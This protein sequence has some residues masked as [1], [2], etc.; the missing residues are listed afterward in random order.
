[1]LI[2]ARKN[3]N[4]LCFF[5]SDAETRN[6]KDRSRTV[7][8]GLDRGSVWV[9]TESSQEH[10]NRF[11]CVPFIERIQ[12]NMGLELPG[13]IDPHLKW[14]TTAKG[15]QRG[16]R[17]ARTSY[18]WGNQKN[19]MVNNFRSE[20]MMHKGLKR[21]G[22]IS[23]SAS[24]KV[25]VSI[26]GRR[27]S[28]SLNNVPIK[29]RKILLVSSPSSTLQS[30]YSDDSDHLLESQ[31]AFYLETLAYDKNHNKRNVAD[32]LTILDDINEEAGDVVD[33]S[34]MSI[35]A[36]AACSS[37]IVSDTL[38]IGGIVSKGYSF[39]AELL[40]ATQGAQSHSSYEDKEW[41]SESIQ[42]LQENCNVPV[43]ECSAFKPA[44]E[45]NLQGSESK[46]SFTVSLQNDS[47]KIR[48]SVSDS[49]L[50]WDLNTVM[51]AWNS[52]SDAA[53]VSEPLPTDPVCENLSHNEKLADFETFQDR[54]GNAE[55]TCSTGLGES[56]ENVADLPKDDCASLKSE[57]WEKPDSCNN[58]SITDH[59][60][61]KR[62]CS[63]PYSDCLLEENLVTASVSLVNSSE[64][65]E[66]VYNQRN[67]ICSTEVVSSIAR[68]IL[69]SLRDATL[70]IEAIDK[71]TADADSGL[72]SETETSLC[73]LPCSGNISSD[74]HNDSHN[75]YLNLVQSIRKPISNE[76][77]NL[78]ASNTE[79]G[80]DDH[81]VANAEVEQLTYI[82]IS[83][84]EEHRVLNTDLE[85][86]DQSSVL[87]EKDC[88]VLF[89][90]NAISNMVETCRS[91]EI[92]HSDDIDVTNGLHAK[93]SSRAVDGSPCLL[94]GH[95]QINLGSFN[96]DVLCSI[97]TCV[98]KHEQSTTELKVDNDKCVGSVVPISVSADMTVKESLVVNAMNTQEAGKSYMDSCVNYS[99]EVALN[100]HVHNYDS[101]ASHLDACQANGMEK[102][103]LLVDEDSQFEDGEFRESVLQSWGED[104]AEERE[105]AHLDYGSDNRENAIVEA[106]SCFPDSLPSIENM[107]GKSRDVSVAIHDGAANI[108]NSLFVVSQPSLMCLSK[109]TSLNS[110]DGKKT[111]TDIGRKD[112][113]DHL[114]VKMIGQ[115]GFQ[116]GENNRSPPASVGM[117]YSGWDR[118][119]V[120]CVH[121][122]DGMLDTGIG[123][124]K[125]DG[126]AG[127][128]DESS[129]NELVGRSGLSFSRGFSSRVERLMSSD[130]SH[131]Q[132]NSSARITRRDSSSRITRSDDH[133]GLNT[134]IE[135]NTG[136]PKSVG[137]GRPSQHPQGMVR[138]VHCFDCS[139]HHCPKHPGSPGYCDA[140]SARPGSRNAAAAAAAKVESNGFVVA[141]DG[142]IAKAG[143][144]GNA[145]RV[146]RQ[147]T[148][149]SSQS[150]WGSQAET[151]LACGVQRRFGNLRDMSPVQHFSVSRSQA[152]KYGHE[153]ARDRYHRPVPDDR[154]NLSRPV[155]HSS[156]RDRGFS[157]QRG[158]LCLSRSRTRSPSRSR[159]PSPHLWTS[160]RR[161]EIGMNNVLGYSRGSRSLRA[162][163]ER[164]R[165]PHLRSSVEDPT[166]RTFASPL[167]YSRWIDERRDSSNHLRE[168]DYRQRSRRSPS[169]KAFTNSKLDSVHSHGRSEPNG[170]H[171][172]LHSDKNPEI[173]GLSR[174]YK[175][176]GSDDRRGCGNRK[177]RTMV[178]GCCTKEERRK[179]KM[180]WLEDPAAAWY[181]L[182]IPNCE[183]T[184]L[185][186]ESVKTVSKSADLKVDDNN[187]VGL[188]A[189]ISI[190]A[191]S[192]MA[193]TILI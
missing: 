7:H 143:G 24:E 43:E 135:R 48:S 133:G 30:T 21:A 160:P 152:G 182:V 94:N 46:K 127:A 40:E 105:S 84:I 81:S 167:H 158:S 192:A 53:V 96:P 58:N 109:S 189:P 106:V 12:S 117:K 20:G 166:L 161:R 186:Q 70:V 130:E 116:D 122:R 100:D 99:G 75:P 27:F 179:D 1:M 163:M 83:Q 16:A 148:N 9:S 149:A 170:H 79:S 57:V 56:L 67:S 88:D 171:C 145:G 68:D 132:D 103:N 66:V 128:L 157:P 74:F 125:Q 131:R 119:P 146:V 29:K 22:D 120:A 18:A 172:H 8:K 73:L 44:D 154:M 72:M 147:S 150:R 124:V 86:G 142:T 107:T 50:H 17:R 136:A 39:E 71:A 80:S 184:F 2:F 3:K 91:G 65:T 51:D 156:R 89:D 59:D 97:I 193:K 23:V 155:H 77:P 176:A 32:N 64:E 183:S 76:K 115:G 181:D 188:V 52:N 61:I 69:G 180:G 93:G 25:G 82:S 47:D 178:G 55:G 13:P 114:T 162:R 11:I 121:I 78:V 126:K 111:S 10:C 144:A 177:P 153:M 191:V 33:F 60:H 112:C 101:D 14:K 169:T 36:A 26:L 190:S 5:L 113:T 49:R 90:E 151:E 174:G 159:I 4:P 85:S 92:V 108:M 41:Q 6:A 102:V 129:A 134:K 165:S 19:C 175:C 95:H 118:L 187:Y 164:M 38:N 139:N 28:D 98:G 34:G 37:E 168:H 35:L 141:A 137:M 42:D 110:G 140:P 138:D 15:R 63:L 62:C 123:S 54:V 104:G 173:A 87:A 45:D 31:L 185:L